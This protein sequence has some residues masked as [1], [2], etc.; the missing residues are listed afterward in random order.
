M[1]RPSPEIITI[2]W[3]NITGDHHVPS[4]GSSGGLIGGLIGLTGSP[5]LILD[6]WL[7][8]TGAHWG[9]LGFVDLANLDPFH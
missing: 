3:L 7:K 6:C 2:V 5:E 4:L 8:S 1:G 9:M